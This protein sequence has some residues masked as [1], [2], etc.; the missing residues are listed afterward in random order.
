MSI[1]VLKAGDFLNALHYYFPQDLQII[2]RRTPRARP[3]QHDQS[4]DPRPHVP[5][6]TSDAPVKSGTPQTPEMFRNTTTFPSFMQRGVESAPEPN[7]PP[8]AWESFFL[9]L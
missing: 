9:A 8:G 4:S 7:L 5:V 1:L 3:I 2:T 6:T